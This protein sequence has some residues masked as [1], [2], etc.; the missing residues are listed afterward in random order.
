MDQDSDSDGGEKYKQIVDKI[1]D[2]DIDKLAHSV[3]SSEDIFKALGV[4]VP[5]EIEDDL[6]SDDEDD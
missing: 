5:A 1:D 4:K 2:V 6:D 3:K